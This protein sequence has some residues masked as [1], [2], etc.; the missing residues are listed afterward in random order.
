MSKILV[1][2]DEEEILKIIKRALQKDGHEVTVISDPEQIRLES[3]GWYDLII[4]DVMM[5]G[6]NGFDLCFKIR[7]LQIVQ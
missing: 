7:I 4:L 3:L 2:D 1:V 6:I 5:P